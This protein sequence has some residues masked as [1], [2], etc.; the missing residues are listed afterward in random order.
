M[1]LLLLAASVFYLMSTAGYVVYLVRQNE[2]VRR[3][4]LGLMLAGFLCQ[5]AHL[6]WGWSQAGH[7]PIRNMHETLLFAAWATACFFLILNLRMSLKVLGVFAAPLVTF[8]MLVATLMPVETHLPDSQRFFGSFWLVL[9]VGAIFLGEAALA[10][11]CGVGILYLI[12]ERA[13][14]SK[15]RKFFYRR[16]PALEFLDN[17]GYLCIVTGFTLM[18]IGLVTGMIF[19]KSVWGRF[20]RW[21]PKEVWSGVTW[22]LYAVLLHE[23]LVVGWRGRRSAIMAIIG[24]VVILF[25]FLGVNLFF[26]GHHGQFTGF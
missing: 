14:K 18:T 26:T 9:H 22:L 1:K 19:A 15:R 12:Q 21:D 10:M 6:I 2:M 17:T 13:I 5:S 11:A 8:I 25:T 24:F 4:S 23:R 3:V 16:L 20:W 7:F